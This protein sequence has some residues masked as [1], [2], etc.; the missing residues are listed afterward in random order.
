[1]PQPIKTA[2]RNG[3]I[4]TNLGFVILVKKWDAWRKTREVW[5]ESDPFG[6]AFNDSDYGMTE[7]SPTHWEPIPEWIIEC[8]RS[9]A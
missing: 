2:P 8:N 5:V 6:N 1:M 7:L 3:P 4:L 9:R